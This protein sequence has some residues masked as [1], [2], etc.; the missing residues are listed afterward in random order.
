[1]KYW[2]QYKKALGALC[3]AMSMGAVV[4]AQDNA[5]KDPGF[6]KGSEAWETYVGAR[7]KDPAKVHS[8]KWAFEIYS[9]YPKWDNIKQVVSIPKGMGLVEVKGWMKTNDVEAGDASW[10][11]ARIGVEFFGNCSIILE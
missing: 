6:E 3:I 4:S 5:L 1:M 2:N 11:K 9:G 7:T 10:K 8:G